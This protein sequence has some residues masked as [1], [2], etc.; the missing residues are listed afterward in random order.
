MPFWLWAGLVGL[1][2]SVAI[3]AIVK[4]I[5]KWKEPDPSV[6]FIHYA[7]YGVGDRK[8]EYRDVTK[9]VRARIANNSLEMFASNISFGDPFP[10][11]P[12]TLTVKYSFGGFTR[13]IVI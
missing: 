1:C 13:T 12:K 8:L 9:I 5:R 4:M 11:V 3:P 7:R 10:S 2:L 6:L